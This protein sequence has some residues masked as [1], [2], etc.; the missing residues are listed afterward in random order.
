M[1]LGGR[2][3]G[4]EHGVAVLNAGTGGHA[5]EKGAGPLVRASG[6]E[7]VGKGN[8]GLVD[9]VVGDGGGDAV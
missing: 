2:L 8:E 5:T 4:G 3:V 7:I 1:E 9:V 6:E